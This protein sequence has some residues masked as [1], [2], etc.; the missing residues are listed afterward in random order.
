[1]ECCW[2]FIPCLGADVSVN[3][4]MCLDDPS[5][6]ARV[7]S[8]SS[9]WRQ[10][11]IENGLSKHLC[12]K[13]FPEIS[14]ITHEIEEKNMIHPVEARPESSSKWEILERDHRVYAFLC[15]GLTSFVRKDCI[16][17]AVSASST[18]N[19]PEESI[20]NT[21]EPSDR[22]EGRA[23]YWSSQ[24]Q[25]DPSVPET[26]LYKLISNFCVITEV[27]VQPFQAY[28]QFGFPIYSAQALRFRMGHFRSSVLG[29]ES[30]VVHEASL[31]TFEWTYTSP[32]FPM[33]QENCLQKFKLPEPVLCIGGYFAVELL[34]R[35]Q[36][37]DMD[38]LYYV[39]VSH[40]QVVGRPLSPGFDVEI[41]DGSGSC[42]LKYNP[43]AE[44]PWSPTKSA[45]ESQSEAAPSS[46]GFHITATWSRIWEQLFPN[47]VL[48]N[49]GVVVAEDEDE[50][51][52]GDD[53]FDDDNNLVA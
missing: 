22:A 51:E 27:N 46:G 7:C 47:T 28:F 13:M 42:T 3:I 39:C 45:N 16:S 25:S 24:G 53:N 35:V 49:G 37:Q 8:V 44:H 15:R 29:S 2:D 10:F 40:V 20:Q 21:L 9:S 32:V 41:I 43:V 36:R 33:A 17:E 38:G 5:D 11:V 18:D 19:F 1:M 14:S 12:L 23:S 31:D 48:G 26:L 30:T 52:D 4:L 34:G 50:N 6:L